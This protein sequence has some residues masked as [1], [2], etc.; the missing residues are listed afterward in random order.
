MTIMLLAT[1]LLWSGLIHPA[2]WLTKKS[3]C[4]VYCHPAAKAKAIQPAHK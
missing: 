2:V 1:S 4:V 3:A